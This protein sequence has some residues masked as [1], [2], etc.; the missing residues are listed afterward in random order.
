MKN[1]WLVK[2][3][4]TTFSFDDLLRAPGKTTVWDGVR[5]PVARKHLRDMTLGDEVFFYHSSADPSAVVGICEVVRAGYPDPKAPTWVVVDLKAVKP[6][7]R[8]VPL[9]ELRARKDLGGMVLLK[10]SRLSVSPVTK[11]EWDTILKMG[12]NP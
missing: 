10:V 2:S 11:A 3:E 4:P 12:A 8:P 5:N 1:Y 6:L 7:A 9:P